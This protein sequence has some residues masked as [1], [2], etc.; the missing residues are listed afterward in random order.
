MTTKSKRQEQANALAT[1]FELQEGRPVRNPFGD[2]FRRRG[3][4]IGVER[5]LE[6]QGFGEESIQQLMCGLTGNG[7]VARR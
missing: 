4:E 2:L 3:F 5:A 6:A 1:A 7:A